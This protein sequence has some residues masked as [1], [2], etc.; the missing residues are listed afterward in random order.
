MRS[1][2]IPVIVSSGLVIDPTL[3]IADPAKKQG[4]VDRGFRQTHWRPG[5]LASAIVYI[6]L[7]GISGRA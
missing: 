7:G 5:G 3:P 6:S 4:R 2:T 1:S